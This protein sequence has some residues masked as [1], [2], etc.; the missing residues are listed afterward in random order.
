MPVAGIVLH[1]DQGP[2]RRLRIQPGIDH[3]A[4]D[5]VVA[6]KRVPV[7]CCSGTVVNAGADSPE[8]EKSEPPE[9]SIEQNCSRGIEI[10]VGDLRTR[11]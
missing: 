3:G 10:G 11:L 7:L 8:V 9:S 2:I 1:Q 6:H 4:A 5:A